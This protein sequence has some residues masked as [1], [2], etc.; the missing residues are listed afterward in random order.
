MA[1]S[2]TSALMGIALIGGLALSACSSTPPSPPD[3]SM[4]PPI[5]CGASALSGR[6]GQPVTGS[7]AQD[8]RVG[9]EPVR[10][11]GS[12]RVIGPGDMVTQDYRENRLNLE[13]SAAG[14]LVRAT[15]G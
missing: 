11:Q 6:T 12:V 9:G 2:R 1:I 5:D 13:V 10:S 15:C 14:S 3:N 7:T 4:P 8:V